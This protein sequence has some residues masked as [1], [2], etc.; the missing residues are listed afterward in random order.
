LPRKKK[1]TN[2]RKKVYKGV[3]YKSELEAYMAKSLDRVGV[4]QVYEKRKFVIREPFKSTNSSYEKF[5][6]GRGLFKDRGN[7]TVPKSVYTPDFTP[8]LDQPLTWIIEVK[9]R[10]MPGFSDRWKLFKK[11]LMDNNQG[12][13]ILFMPRTKEDCDNTV[14]IIKE[15]QTK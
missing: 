4:P 2:A 10:T 15:M 1:Q 14:E 8:P 12:D 11:S 6:N 5:L 13:V 9:G 3:T 7:K